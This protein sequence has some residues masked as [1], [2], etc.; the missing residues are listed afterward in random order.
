MKT[1]HIFPYIILFS[2]FLPW[3]HLGFTNQIR[4]KEFIVI[5]L[6]LIFI[7]DRLRGKAIYLDYSGKIYFSFIFFCI[8]YTIFTSFNLKTIEEIYFLFHVL[9]FTILNFAIYLVISNID[10][11]NFNFKKLINIIVIIYISVF[12]YFII[13]TTNIHNLAEE[14][15]R[16][17]HTIENELLR[18]N[19]LKTY[20][21]GTNG[22]SWFF[23]LISSFLFGYFI[24]KKNYIFGL[25]PIIM[26]LLG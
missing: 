9:L 20:L 13:Y 16:G 22:S 15:L 2:F 3:T 4:I 7:F 8:F 25:V 12:C 23:L 14:S 5:S 18:D 6:V 10:L 1:D 19:K 24:K 11:K 17:F 26:S 21:G